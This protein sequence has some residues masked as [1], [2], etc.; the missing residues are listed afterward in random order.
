MPVQLYYAGG[1]RD[2]TRRTYEGGD[3]PPKTQGCVS[4]AHAA[5]MH[6]YYKRQPMTHEGDPVMSWLD[7]SHEIERRPDGRRKNGRKPA[8]GMLPPDEE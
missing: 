4:E 3:L 7:L 8:D 6:G 2:G 1:P 5:G